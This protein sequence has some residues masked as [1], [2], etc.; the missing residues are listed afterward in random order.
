MNAYEMAWDAYHRY[1]Q[2][3]WAFHEVLAEH[4]RRGVVVCLPDAFVMARRVNVRDS[5]ESH[6]SPLESRED[7][8]CWM[9]WLAAGRIRSLLELLDL[10]PA[11]WISYQRR[12]CMRLCRVNTETIRRHVLAKSSQATASP[13]DSPAGFRDWS[14]K[15]T[16][17]SGTT[18]AGQGPVFF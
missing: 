4:L 10:R 9:V 15:S 18:P 11:R 14:G 5:D 17:R 1:G 6:L 13:A 8:D 12:D 7:G 16:S 2:P 3:G